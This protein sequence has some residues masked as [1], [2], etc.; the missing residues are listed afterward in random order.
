MA[1]DWAHRVDGGA[2]VLILYG[3]GN[4]LVAW[5]VLSGR[6]TVAGGF[7]PAAQ[8]GHAVLWDPLFFLWGALLAAGLWATRRRD[9]V[10]TAATSR[11]VGALNEA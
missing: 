3:A 9:S 5:A 8:W 6:I 10:A 7:D 1:T 4:T 11:G 2:G